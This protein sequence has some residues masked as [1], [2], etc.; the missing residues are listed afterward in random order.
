MKKFLSFFLAL[1][2]LA[3]CIGFAAAEEE[4]AY[5]IGLSITTLEFPFFV[6]MV[7]GFIASSEQRGWEYIYA[8]GGQ[9]IA[10]QLSDC[11]D[12]MNQGI[13][14]LLL[15]TWYGDA[16][17]GVI[18]DMSDAGIPVIL[19]DAS[20]PP[21]VDFVSDVGSDNLESGRMAGLWAGDYI[22][23]TQG[24]TE[25]NFA[26]LVQPSPEGRNRADG[27]KQGLEE[28][29][30]AVNMLNSYD[31]SSRETSMANAEDALVT[32]PNIDLMFG[33][34]AQGSL[35]A[36]DACTAAKRDDVL[37][38]GYDC[39]QEEADLIDAKANYIASVK[40]DP[41]GLVEYA[42]TVL[43]AYEAGEEVERLI[44]FDNSLYTVEGEFTFTELREL[45]K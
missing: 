18:Q 42:M 26:E 33:A 32:Y 25:V 27:F 45:A 1:V 16:M 31:A 7:D 21:E 41:A 36:N 24:K 37:I 17:S 23:R 9:D 11:E 2:L 19:L 28:S 12:L 35:G 5:K 30:L 22:Q 10:K 8:D 34:C 6:S 14:A 20:R 40:Q 44:A 15:C 3:T 4:G 13:D 39:E 29:G 38:V 43:E